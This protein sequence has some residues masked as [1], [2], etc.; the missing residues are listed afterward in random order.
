MCKRYLNDDD[1][2]TP[3]QLQNQFNQRTVD[4][5]IL[6]DK[7]PSYRVLDITS[8]IF[9][10]SFNPYWHKSIGGYSPAKLQR[11]QDLIDRYL[12]KEI[13]SLY[14][15]LSGAKTIA[16]MEAA[17]PE[18]QMLS[19]LNMKYLIVSPD[20][21]P[22]TNHYAFGNAWFVDSFVDAATP[23]DEIG[24]IATTNLR[25]TA[26]IGADFKDAVSSFPVILSK[27]KD[28]D[29]VKDLDTIQ[30]T[31]YSPDELHYHYSA[32]S[33]RPVVFSEVYYPKG[34]HASIDGNDLPL[35]RAD[36]I[37]RGAILPAG[38]HDIVMRFDPKIYTVSA[39]VSRAS[40]ITLFLL[41]AA[42]VAGMFLGRKEETE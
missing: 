28:L 26:I 22:V 17:L 23:D 33:D 6:E 24:L 13:Q 3:R 35:Y 16:D 21:P 8:D 7:S 10:D 34:W 2:V 36:W 38:E 39:N 25:T 41:L 20:A 1:F 29:E 4:K 11:Y 12:I 37:L 31:Y 19:A 15:P 14:T 42:A 18:K 40:S 30:M 5:I 32:A 27:A 9:N